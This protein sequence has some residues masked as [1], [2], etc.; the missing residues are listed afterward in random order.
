MKLPGI[1]AWGLSGKGGGGEGAA[2]K[3]CHCLLELL[4]WALCCKLAPPAG[5]RAAQ[6]ST[7]I[8]MAQ[9]S[10]ARFKGSTQDLVDILKKFAR[11]PDF[12]VYAEALNAPLNVKRIVK[13]GLM[14]KEVHALSPAMTFADKFMQK[15]FAELA[16]A[17]GED[18]W[19][20]KLSEPEVLL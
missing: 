20:K 7:A 17:C 15:V 11:F 1:K 12:F 18:T 9:A 16:V 13:N 19:P 14:W 8:N 2:S 10:R 3:T 5:D 4:E 6:A